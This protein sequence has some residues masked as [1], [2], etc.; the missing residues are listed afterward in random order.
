MEIK[1]NIAPLLD[2]LLWVEQHITELDEQG[3]RKWKVSTKRCPSVLYAGSLVEIV[4]ETIEQ[5]VTQKTVEPKPL[6]KTQV[7]EQELIE[8]LGEEQ[9]GIAKIPEPVKARRGRKPS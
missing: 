1:H 9:V 8:E 4:L 6:T 5:P 2:S 7:I 3:N